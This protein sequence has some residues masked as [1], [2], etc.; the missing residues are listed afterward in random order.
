[1]VER[2]WRLAKS[3]VP[4]ENGN[5]EQ[6]PWTQPISADLARSWRSMPS[7]PSSPTILALG[8][9]V[10][11][12]I[13]WLPVPQAISK[14]NAVPSADRSARNGASAGSGDFSRCGWLS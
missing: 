2:Y 4:V 7:D 10:R 13:S 14:S 1:M 8:A 12:A 6:S 11:L 5:A 9:I 3:N